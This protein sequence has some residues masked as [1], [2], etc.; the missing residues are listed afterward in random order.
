[1]TVLVK[2]PLKEINSRE[3]R[4]LVNEFDRLIHRSI[5]FTNSERELTTKSDGTSTQ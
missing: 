3:R 4:L 2:P 1:M 5:S